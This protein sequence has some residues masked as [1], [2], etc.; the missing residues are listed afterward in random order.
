M[1]PRTS[2][3]RARPRLLPD[4]LDGRGC[5]GA[6]RGRPAT[7]G[8]GRCSSCSTPRASGSAR[9]QDSTSSTSRSTAA[10]SGSSGRAIASGSCRSATSRIDWLRRWLDEGRPLLLE[11]G[12]AT[13]RA[14]RAAVP[15]RP[16]RPACPAAGV[17][18]RP[19]D[20]RAPRDSAGGSART[21][22]AT[23]SRRI[24]SRAGPTCGSFRNCSDMRVSP[25]PS[26]TPT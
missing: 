9:R 19:V 1:S 4:T 24:S 16:R 26:S 18:D 15:R 14:R 17:R 13:G 7:C 11:L 10:S 5:R 2:T 20:D 23:R 22:S 8:H 12:H 25:R 3:C 6:P 21:P